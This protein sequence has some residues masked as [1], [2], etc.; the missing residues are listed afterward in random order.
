LGN[1]PASLNITA[2]VAD[3]VIETNELFEIST[4]DVPLIKISDVKLE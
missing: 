4:V 1:S 2:V 3:D